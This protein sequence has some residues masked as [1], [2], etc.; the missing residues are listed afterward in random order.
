MEPATTFK[1][2]SFKEFEL[3]GWEISVDGYNTGFTSLTNQVNSPILNSLALQ[4][5]ESF[6]D[7]ATG[8][9][10]LAGLAH[11][12][13]A[14][15]TA[16]DFSP[17]MLQKAQNLQ[18]S[19][20]EFQLADVEDLPFKEESFDKAAMSFGILHLENPEKALKEAGRVVKRGG[21]FTFTVW[22]TPERALGFAVMMSAIKEYGNVALEQPEGPPFFYYSDPNV[23]MESLRSAGFDNCTAQ[24]LEINWILDNERQFF[25]AFHLGTART[26]GLL[27]AQTSSQLENIK[28]EVAHL[29]KE[30]F[31]LNGKLVIP[32]NCLLY[33]GVKI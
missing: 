29:T 19:E 15:V 22:N 33:T 3:R 11:K 27:R 24:E 6:L 30:R 8:P 26:G 23:S 12:R 5:G 1:N 2:L 13:K 16:L 28:K 17:N 25:D 4:E 21:R 18:A 31:S 32:M 14:S 9:G 10:F 7:L 20:I